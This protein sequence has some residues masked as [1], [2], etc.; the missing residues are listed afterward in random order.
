MNTAVKSAVRTLRILE[1]FSAASGPLALAEVARRLD[2]P[3]SSAHVLIATLVAEGYL[4]PAGRGAY[5]LAEG[6]GGPG[7][8]V[9]GAAGAIVR[10]A[11]PEIHRLVDRFQ[12][13]VVLGMPT[14][15]GNIRIATYKLSP[16]AVRF[17]VSRDP[18]LPAWCTAMGHAILSHL[19]E[20]EVRGYLA[21]TE[22]VALTARTATDER[23][24][25]AR[26]TRAR[27]R[28]HATNIDERFDG[29]SGAAVA[30][31]DRD[32][33]PRA[34]INLVTLTPRFRKRQRE[35]VEGLQAAARIIETTVFASA[36]QAVPRIEGASS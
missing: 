32:G 34:A 21:R 14:A 33:A 35:I 2:L 31:L 1:L 18:E 24:I 17:D 11:M 36:G 30:I 16:L 8:W 22:R 4:E 20:A 19:P 7:G 15:S 28:G 12:E 27:L 5:I 23:E 29:A 3:K 9:G 10:A 25:L 26:L 13:T 6:L